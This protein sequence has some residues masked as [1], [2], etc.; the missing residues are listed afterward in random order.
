MREFPHRRI[1][2]SSLPNNDIYFRHV[3]LDQPP[4]SSLRISY[5]TGLG[6]LRFLGRDLLGNDRGL[7]VVSGGIDRINA[8]QLPRRIYPAGEL[9]TH[10]L[11]NC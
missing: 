4:S 8:N 2:R 9:E 5:T 7:W 6:V 10:A 1:I 11:A 3:A